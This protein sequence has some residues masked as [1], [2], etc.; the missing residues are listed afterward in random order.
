MTRLPDRFDLWVRKARECPDPARQAD[1]VL[2]AL[3]ALKEWY[4][5]NIGTKENP[6][7]AEA[8]VEGGRHLLVFSDRDRI[9]AIVGGKSHGKRTASN[10]HHP[11]GCRDG[12]VYR[13]KSGR[14]R[15]LTGESG[16]VRRDNLS[17]ATGDFPCRM[18]SAVDSAGHRVLDSQPHDG[19]RGFL[20]GAWNIRESAPGL[21]AWSYKRSF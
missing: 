4:F 1:Y 9:E 18:E 7:P 8:E 2:G 5:L 19:G 11:H 16:R 21:T 15:R 3:S 20:A 6:Q 10:Y 14:M 17:L 13:T 12:L